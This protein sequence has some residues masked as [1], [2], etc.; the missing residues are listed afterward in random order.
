MLMLLK[1]D[2][3][4]K[5]SHKKIVELDIIANL[6]IYLDN[7]LKNNQSTKFPIEKIVDSFNSQIIDNNFKNWIVTESQEPFEEDTFTIKEQKYDVYQKKIVFKIDINSNVVI[8][9]KI[10]FNK[11]DLEKNINFIYYFYDDIFGFSATCLKSDIY[12]GFT[13]EGN[14]IE[15]YIEALSSHDNVNIKKSDYTLY[16]PN[17]EFTKLLR[18]HLFANNKSNIK[19]MER[20]FD[21]IFENKPISQQYIDEMLILYDISVE[22]F[23]ENSFIF[24]FNS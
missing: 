12:T 11:L 1:R 6:K 4:M 2:Y 21:S 15:T 16:P 13:W 20:I 7:C 3:V 9:E 23:F 5:N 24:N 8:F 10:L 14:K 22:D 17:K 19:V 18:L